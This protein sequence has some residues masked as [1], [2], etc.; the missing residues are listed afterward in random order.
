[1]EPQ[2]PY[3]GLTDEERLANRECFSIFLEC[4]KLNT[5]NSGQV[6]RASRIARTAWEATQFIHKSLFHNTFV[7]GTQTQETG[8]WRAQSRRFNAG[9]ASRKS[10]KVLEVT[11]NNS[12]GLSF[13]NV[14]FDDS[15][16]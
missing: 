15:C 6:T 8:V 3:P 11:A 13:F 5:D 9:T 12:F 10:T 1:M 7:H 14:F 16:L 2:G 4:P